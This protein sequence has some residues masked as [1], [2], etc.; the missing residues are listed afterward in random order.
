MVRIFILLAA[1]D[2]PSSP[3]VGQEFAIQ[4][5]DHPVA[6]GIGFAPDVRAEVDRTHDAIAELLVDELLDG[7]AV[8]LDHLIEPVDRRVGRHCRLQR[9]RVG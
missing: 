6:A 3:L 8:N 7:R 1:A 4:R 9:P 2:R 5:D